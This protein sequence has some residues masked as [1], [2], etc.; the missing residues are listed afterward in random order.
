MA[1]KRGRK[2]RNA[3]RTPS[4]QISR[5]KPFRIEPRI[6][7]GTDRAQAVQALYGNNGT[8]AIGRAYEAGFLGQGNEAKA[9]LDKARS[10]F[11]AYWSAY[12]VGQIRKSSTA[13]NDNG[14]TAVPDHERIR[15]REEGLREDLH[16]VNRMGPAYRRAFDQLCID[17]NPD[18]G[19]VW[20]DQLLWADKHGKPQ[21]VG[22]L[23]TLRMAIEALANIS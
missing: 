7:K 15:Q 14:S 9:L 4:G 12:G 20:L 10:V 16:K 19:P 18:E 6:D 23:R 11:T 22:H 21:D 17:M 3:A 5:A 8:D 13:D 2:R 1:K